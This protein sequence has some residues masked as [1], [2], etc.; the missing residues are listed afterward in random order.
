LFAG[1]YNRSFKNNTWYII[2]GGPKIG[3][4]FV[5]LN[6]TKNINRFSKLFHCRNQE[7]ICNNTTTKNPATPP[8]CIVNNG[9]H[10]DLRMHYLSASIVNIWNSLPNHV[11]DVDTVILS[12]CS[13]HAYTGSGRTK[14]S[15]MSNT[16]SRPT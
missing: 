10:Y 15:N 11:V 12:T 3:T 13:K 5:R 4:I 16:I 9:F 7:K 1:R 14:M 8:V 2:Q 6:F